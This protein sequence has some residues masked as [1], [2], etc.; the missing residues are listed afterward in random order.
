MA[1]KS[2]QVRLELTAIRDSVAC[3]GSRDQVEYGAVLAITDD[4]EVWTWGTDFS[5]PNGGGSL[6]D[7]LRAL[8]HPRGRVNPRT[9]RALVPKPPWELAR[10]VT[11]TAPGR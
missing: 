7:A 2:I 8:T 1:N 11:N 3:F 6:F 4:G 5:R 10:F 9:T